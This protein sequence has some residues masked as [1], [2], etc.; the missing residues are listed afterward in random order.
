VSKGGKEKKE[1]EKSK[2]GARS[3][4]RIKKETPHQPRKDF[5]RRKKNE[6]EN[7]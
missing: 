6:N 2:E 7:K 4:K 3:E 1:K 5:T